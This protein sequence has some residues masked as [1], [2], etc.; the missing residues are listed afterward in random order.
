[1]WTRE[2]WD[3]DD[4]EGPVAMLVSRD[5]GLLFVEEEFVR[6]AA[7]L[8]YR[9]VV[10]DDFWSVLRHLNDNTPTEGLDA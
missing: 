6:D 1:M 8:R 2:M 5:D 9:V 7:R 4:G 10:F 3:N